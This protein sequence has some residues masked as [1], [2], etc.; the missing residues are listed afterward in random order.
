MKSGRPRFRA[1]KLQEKMH[2][3]LLNPSTGIV[4][5]WKLCPGR[6]A[7]P[8][9]P[10]AL[11]HETPFLPRQLPPPNVGAATGAPEE[12]APPDAAALAGVEHPPP[13]RDGS[14]RIALGKEC[15]FDEWEPMPFFGTFDW[16]DPLLSGDCATA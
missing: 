5:S 16:N 11:P 4:A 9:D 6:E 8:L 1:K 14:E 12:I 13:V 7:H 15:I 10:D 2:I 3:H